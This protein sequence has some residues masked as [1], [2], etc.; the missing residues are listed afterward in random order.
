MTA[1]AKL[2]WRD[3]LLVV[4]AVGAWIVF[5]GWTARHAGVLGAAAAVAAGILASLVTGYVAHEWGHLVAAIWAGGKAHPNALTNPQLFRFDLEE[6]EARAYQWMGWGGNLAPWLV[7]PAALV[8]APPD[9]PGRA[10]FLLAAIA[11]AAF[12]NLTECP[13]LLR[14]LREGPVRLEVSAAVYTRNAMVAVVVAAAVTAVLGGA[15]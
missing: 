10:A 14:S 2:A 1:L 13:V 3:G 7:V 15:G 4:V 5:D 11:G 9:S 8:W 6:N 12:V